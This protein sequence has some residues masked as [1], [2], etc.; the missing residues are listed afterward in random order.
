M[1]PPPFESWVLA[2][3]LAGLPL[4]GELAAAAEPW[5]PIAERLDA[6]PLNPTAYVSGSGGVVPPATANPAQNRQALWDAFLLGQPDR[7]D[8][9]RAVADAAP[10]DPA[11]PIEASDSADDWGPIRLGTLPPAETFPLDVLPLSARDLAEAAAESIACPV[12]FPAVAM[13]AAASGIIG[14]SA[15][16]MIKP[17]YFASAALYVALVGNPSS[18]KTPAQHAALAPVLSI[19]GELHDEWR[20]RMDAWKAAK[21]DER[22]EEPVLRRLVTT[23]PTT[24]ALGPILAKNPRGLILAPDEMTKWVMSMDQYKGGKGGDRPFYLSAWNGEPVYVDRAKHQREPIVVPH[25]FLTVVG[26]LA[27]DMLSALPEE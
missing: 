26:G 23:D 18:G 1:R 19:A 7:D 4:N 25:P 11:P 20:P 17:G 16:L 9:L 22:G 27:P 10:L 24:E 5:R 12:D 13:L 6:I 21:S 2:R 15:C 8:I 14:R 3:I